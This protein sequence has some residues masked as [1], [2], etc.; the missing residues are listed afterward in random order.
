MKQEYLTETLKKGDTIEL[1]GIKYTIDSTYCTRGYYT[2]PVKSSYRNNKFLYTVFKGK[3][4][5]D[6]YFRNFQRKVL[7]YSR[8]GLCPESDSLKDLT[9]FINASIYVYHNKS[10]KGF[11]NDICMGKSIIPAF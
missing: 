11:N 8:K 6:D 4:I 1:F 9:K 7:N 10:L 3:T 2:K 5:H